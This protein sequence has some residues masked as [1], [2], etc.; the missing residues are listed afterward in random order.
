MSG[1]RDRR[2]YIRRGTLDL[3]VKRKG[4]WTLRGD[5]RGGFWEAEMEILGKGVE[6]GPTEAMEK[7][8]KGGGGGRTRGSERENEGCGSL[9][10]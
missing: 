4:G 1:A 2:E 5:V 3:I 10:T 7:L 6:G 9:E 8:K